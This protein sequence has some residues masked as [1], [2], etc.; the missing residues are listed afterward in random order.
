MTDTD[1]HHEFEPM[2]GDDTCMYL[3]TSGERCMKFEG[4]HSPEPEVPEHL[5]E[6]ADRLR[7]QFG[8]ALDLR[9]VIDTHPSIAAAYKAAVD[10]RVLDG[11]TRTERV[12]KV[13]LARGARPEF[14]LVEPAW[15]GGVYRLGHNHVVVATRTGGPKAPKGGWVN[16]AK[17]EDH[18]GSEV[19]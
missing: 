19:L 18:N 1:D 10:V 4:E 2:P 7:T 9:A 17:V 5:R 3:L 13:A 6:I 12:G 11:A 16:I 14:L 8:D 15:K